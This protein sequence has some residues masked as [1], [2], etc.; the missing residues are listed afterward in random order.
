MPESLRLDQLL[1]EFQKNRVH[2]AMLLDEYGGVVGMVSLENVLEELVGPIQ[3]EFDRE[4]PQVL[5]LGGD[6]FEVD[7]TCPLDV[8]ATSCGLDVPETEAETAGGLIL[9]LLGRLAKAGDRVMVDGHSLTVIAGRPDTNP[10]HPRRAGGLQP[11]W[12]AE[13]EGVVDPGDRPWRRGFSPSGPQTSASKT[14][15]TPYPPVA[16]HELR[17]ISVAEPARRGSRRGPLSCN[18]P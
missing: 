8:F 12:P 9:D 7:A 16:V 6:V 10:D 4:T 3:D 17:P 11:A 5:D 18:R 1:A 2:L 15:C 13:V 14:S